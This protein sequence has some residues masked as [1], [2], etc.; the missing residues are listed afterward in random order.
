[1]T[2]HPRDHLGLV[3]LVAGPEQRAGVL[4][5]RQQ[6]QGPLNQDLSP[7]RRAGHRILGNPGAQSLLVQALPPI[8]WQG[9]RLLQPCPRLGVGIERSLGHEG[10]ALEHVG[11]DELRMLQQQRVQAIRHPQAIVIKVVDQGVEPLDSR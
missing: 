8:G 6:V 9:F 1:L 7:G 2:G 10:I 11:K 5:Q 3:A 4:A